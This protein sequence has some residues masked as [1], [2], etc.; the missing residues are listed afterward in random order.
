MSEKVERAMGN[1]TAEMMERGVLTESLTQQDAAQQD[2]GSV[3]QV[4]LSQKFASVQLNSLDLEFDDD[5]RALWVFMKGKGRPCF[6][7]ELLSDLAGAQV[8]I[9]RLYETY[10]RAMPEPI[11]YNVIASRNPLIYNLGGDLGLFV[12]LIKQRERLALEKYAVD[13]IDVVYGNAISLNLPYITVGLVQGDALGG[14]FETALSCDVIIAERQAKF[15]LP[16]VLFNLFPGM[17]AY[18]FLSRKVDGHRAEEMMMSGRIY[19]AE[20]LQELGLV[21][22]VV[23]PGE[24]VAATQDYIQRNMRKFNAHSAIYRSGRVVKP[25]SYQE[26]RQ[27]VDL[28]VEAA[29]QLSSSDLRKMERLVKAQNR[30]DIDAKDTLAL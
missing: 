27:V 28:W 9:K 14:G 5:T 10:R 18:S 19:T 16:E 30:F 15:G 25:V 7:P 12:D 22:V 29:L 11:R 1:K 13:C 8:V 2:A 4:S 24:G 20:E 23:E 3:S 17:G 26:L 6:S 21:D